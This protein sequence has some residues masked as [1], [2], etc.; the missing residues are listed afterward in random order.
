MKN[1]IEKYI[2]H[3]THDGE[4]QIRGTCPDRLDGRIDHLEEEAQKEEERQEEMVQSIDNDNQECQTTSRKSGGNHWLGFPAHCKAQDRWSW[5]GNRSS[6]VRQPMAHHPY[7]LHIYVT[8]I[9]HSSVAYTSTMDL[10]NET[11]TL[12]KTATA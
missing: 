9:S 3:D 4:L 8:V 7:C 11:K 1:I 5:Q 6:A 2:E 12:I 10:I